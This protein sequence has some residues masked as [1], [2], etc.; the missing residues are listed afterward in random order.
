L[1]AQVATQPFSQINQLI[2]QVHIRQHQSKP[3][4]VPSRLNDLTPAI[5]QRLT[6]LVSLIRD[7]LDLMPGVAQAKWNRKLAITDSKREAT[8]LDGLQA[9]GTKRGLPAPVVRA[10]F[11]AQIT[12]AKLIQE[13][14]F[15]DWTASQQ[16]PFTQPPDLEREI[17][18]KIDTLNE[19]M[20]D[21]LTQI[22]NERSVIAADNVDR[23]A[24]NVFDGSKETL[25][26]SK[27]VTQAAL[28][29]LRELVESGHP[30]P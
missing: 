13:Q 11:Q 27:D 29:S 26:H 4:P 3:R 6:E 17:R 7:R 21:A 15:A 10:F 9:R 20:L 22:W 12:A 8:L 14:R 24:N 18:P 1:P 16:P 28:K 5:Q 25:Q 23:A 2:L 19:Q 30:I